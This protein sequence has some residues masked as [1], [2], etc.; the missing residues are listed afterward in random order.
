MRIAGRCLTLWLRI[1]TRVLKAAKNCYEEN[2][3]CTGAN[4]P[5]KE[6]KPDGNDMW[7]SWLCLKI[8]YPKMMPNTTIFSLR[9]H[10]IEI[11]I[12]RFQIHNS[13]AQSDGFQPLALSETMDRLW[14]S[15]HNSSSLTSAI[16]GHICIL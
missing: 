1:W 16:A 15:S 7:V 3:L 9:K 14:A 8:C 5:C 11:G 12:T 2:A 13:T 10:A 4:G 6:M